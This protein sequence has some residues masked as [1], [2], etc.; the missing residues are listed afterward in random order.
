ML[1]IA[2]VED[3]AAD[4]EQLKGH[5]KKYEAETGTAMKV[6]VFRDGELF[7]LN[8]K[9][10]FDIVFMDIKLVGID[11]M[12]AARRLR[13]IDQKIVIVFVTSMAQYAIKGY[14][15]DACDFAVKPLSYA[16]FYIKMRRAVE[17]VKKDDTD[18]ITVKAP[19]N[20]VKISASS[21]Y[22][23]EVIKHDLIWHTVG[24]EIR[25]HGTMREVEDMLRPFSFYRVHH[26]YLV[27]LAY[28][29]AVRGDTITVN[30]VT[31]NISRAKKGDFM[32]KFAQ[33]AKKR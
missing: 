15:V 29:F 13:T 17:R 18:M 7:L 31:I 28:V 14:E 8:Y 5:I 23:V 3:D 9:T 30:D 24:G 16:D 2:I 22:Y 4:A 12:E 21:V 10:H 27:N 26:S 6:Q 25:S 32:V 19:G 20:I 11:G 1:N 33:F